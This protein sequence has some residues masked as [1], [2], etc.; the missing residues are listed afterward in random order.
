MGDYCDMVKTYATKLMD[1]ST[2]STQ[3]CKFVRDVEPTEGGDFEECYELVMKE[4]REKLSWTNGKRAITIRVTLSFFW[5]SACCSVTSVDLSELSRAVEIYL[6]VDC[7]NLLPTQGREV[8]IKCSLCSKT[9]TA[10]IQSVDR[11]HLCI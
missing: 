4:I 1:F 3:L 11:S 5:F 10:L 6:L 9:F 8:Y 2:D 7:I